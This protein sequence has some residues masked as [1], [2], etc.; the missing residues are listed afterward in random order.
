MTFLLLEIVANLW[1]AKSHQSLTEKTIVGTCSLL[2]PAPPQMG[3]LAILSL[4]GK[5][6]MVE[7]ALDF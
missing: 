5:R 2:S 4:R 3:D 7:E 6:G 1:R